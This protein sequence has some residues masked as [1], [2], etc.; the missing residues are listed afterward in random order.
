MYDVITWLTNNFNTHIAQFSQSNGNHLIKFGQLIENNQ[1]N[2]L[3]QNS[4]RK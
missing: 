3:F 2:I 1:I 4:F